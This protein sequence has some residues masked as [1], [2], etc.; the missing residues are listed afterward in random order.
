M[1]NKKFLNPINLVNLSSDP[2]SASEG[3]IYYNTT[4][5]AVKVYANGAWVPVGN[6]GGSD[7][8]V[9]TT[10]PSSPATGDAWYKN[11]TG[12]FYV[13]DGTYWVEVNGVIEGT[14][15]FNTISVSGQSNVVADSSTDTLTLVAG[16]N[17]SITTNATNDSITINADSKATSSVYLVRNNTGS[18]ILK[19]TLVF[20]SG[21][22]PS[23]RIDVEPFAAVGGI[24]SELTVMG[25]ATANISSG[26]NGEVISFGTLT[27][28][29]TRGDTTSAIAVGDET[30]AAG[31]I[32]FA[33][34][35][36]AGKLTNVRPQHD[37]A[38]A[39]ITVRHASTGQIAVRIVPGN[40]HLEWMHDV[41]IDTPAD[42]EVLA[43]DNSS[44]LWKNQTASEAGLSA[45]DH[46]HTVDSLSN[47]VITG[48]P[49]D[50]QA[51]VWDTTTSKWVNETVSAVTDISSL[52]D[53]TISGTIADNEVLVYDTATSQWINQTASEADL[54]TSSSIGLD[55]QAYAPGLDSLLGLTNT[56]F[57]TRTGDDAFSIDTNSYALN[58]S[59][60]S[61][62]P[63]A[64]PELTG[65][66]L[67]T[68]PTAG[69]NSTAIATTAFVA[70]SFATKDAPT[71]TGIVVLPST[72][73]IG[74][75]SDTEIGY[76]NGVTS[77]IQTQLDSK[78]TLTGGEISDTV[79]PDTIARVED[80]SNSTTG[81]IP[82]SAKGIAGGVA[83]LDDP[84]GKVPAIQLDL[85]AYAPLSGPTFTGIV[86]LPSATSI[87]DVTSTEIGY[88]DGVTSSIQTQ[89]G[90]LLSTATAT[91]TYLTKADAISDYQPK[92]LDLTNI[93]AL[94]TTGI[95]VRGTDS[96]YTTV[97]N[98]SS[99]WDTA[100]T[101][102]NK[103]DGGSSGL[104]A[105]SARTSLGLVIGTDV[106]AYSSHLAGINTLGSG[107]GLLKNT[108][109]TWS[110][111]SSTYALSSSLSGY[112]P[113][114]GD[115]S[116]IAAITSGVGLL[117]RLGPDSW[118]IDTNS[119][120]T[121]SSPT[122]STSLISGT[123][124]FNLI[125]ATATTVNFAGAATT[126]I[127]GSTDAG[128]STT[129]RTPAIV[130]TSTSLD[131]FNTTATTVNLA[132]A[133]TTLTIGGTPTGSVT[134][135]L[136]GNATT[137]TKTINIGTGGASGS[138]TNINIGSSTSGATGTVSVYPSTNFVGTVTVP[139]PTSSGHATTK[140]YVDALAAGINVKPQVVYVSQTNLNAT[141]AAGT[142]DS[143]GGLGVGA[144]LTGA[145]DGALILDGPEVEAGQ[146]VL[147]KD[148]TVSVQNGIY[149]V[150][151]AGDGDD[152]FILTRATNFNGNT[153]TN[154]LIKNG[155][156]VFVT[157]GT[158]S[159]NDSYVVSQGGTS[160][161]PS[162]AI[163]VGTDNIIFAQ[164]S[165]VPNNISTLG[166][167]TTG[168]WAA[169]PIDKDFIDVEIA[170][171]NDPVFTGHVTVPSPTD[172]TDAANKEYV[173][174]LIFA[175]LPYLPDIIPL[176]D[177]RYEFNDMDSRFV[178]KFQGEQV[179]INNPL[180]LLLTINGI[181]QTVDFPEYVWQSMLPREG[182][183]VDSDGYIAFSEVPPVGST[184]DARLML[185]PNVN[186]IKKGYPFK[187]VDILLGA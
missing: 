86:I 143:S 24:N 83:T 177:L 56:G 176:D 76:L 131:L 96:T 2:A 122:I 183:M 153:S 125:N 130:T 146:R 68:T 52:T 137:S 118:S 124:T 126:L 132:G 46:N 41:T 17:V 120:I 98:N 77:A 151:F 186:S 88:L 136:F 93:S 123:S 25:M 1:A 185:G 148:Q 18:T 174:D 47:V 112:Q 179:A 87:G 165:G 160:T 159:A 144:T 163:K 58:S 106:Q 97:T 62:A 164:Y 11:D 84:S 155:D 82:M 60:S 116:A 140:S 35:T 8:N 65:S 134:A 103:W 172:D 109:G 73:S 43:Y 78:P 141:Y 168:T 57:V 64:S 182:F 29:D 37:L 127:M 162:G 4:S 21:A 147:I 107:T 110:Y 22:E 27:G 167:V 142:S 178:P 91:A 138:E 150:T 187:A 117:K 173:D 108:A 102:R 23:G 3:D 38:V 51:L 59:L 48:T 115:L 111:D 157:S 135:T 180:R 45:S 101:D 158:N 85:T 152:P 10:A 39:F 16:T 161:T 44:G 50:G 9:S 92:D 34:P 14:N 72:T 145:V 20:A 7:I 166:Y 40:N 89:L 139:T 31:D 90:N 13:Y 42:N 99:N 121:G 6:D 28:I 74:D 30:W 61:Y 156:Y 55:V 100:Y 63:L 129:I 12:E 49:T 113:V 71:F 105:T 5:D 94:S 66:P 154:G 36:V 184:F 119:Y 95:V 33:H 114:D 53:V 128:A 26:V 171:T 80:I 67:A 19:G 169:T 70:T 81:Y 54:L 75:V 170:R 104:D 69:D 175:S 149:V 15:T 79:I 133:V 32:L 181:I